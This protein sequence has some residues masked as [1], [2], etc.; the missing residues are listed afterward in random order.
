MTE[1]P[2]IRPS[3]PVVID[4]LQHR[5]D[6]VSLSR[7][8]RCSQPG[9]TLQARRRDTEPLIRVG[10]TCSR[11]LGNAVLRNRARRRLRA[12]AGEV[13]PEAGL[14]GWDYVL[15]G[16]PGST[17]ARAFHDLVEDMRRALRSVHGVEAARP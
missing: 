3:R 2:E 5:S 4:R 9:F 11:K 13:L 17:V 10:F 14:A 16:R 15:V 6:F 7:A 8:R 12:V 1:A